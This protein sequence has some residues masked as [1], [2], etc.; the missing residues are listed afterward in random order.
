LRQLAAVGQRSRGTDLEQV[1]RETT[2]LPA[3]KAADGPG[4]DAG[5]WLS[6]PQAASVQAAAIVVRA[7]AL[8]D[9]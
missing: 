7:K 2:R 6:P 9:T 8:R 3:A 4:L 1:E 5:V